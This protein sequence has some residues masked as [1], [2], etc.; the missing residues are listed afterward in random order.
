MSSNNK[1][2]KKQV[3]YTNEKYHDIDYLNTKKE[4]ARDELDCDLSTC[5]IKNV[6]EEEYYK[7]FKQYYLSGYVIVRQDWEYYSD[8]SFIITKDEAEYIKEIKAELY[9]YPL[10]DYSIGTDK[11]LIS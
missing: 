5:I 2:S 9:K 4:E 11:E 7:G 1:T 10:G 6:I 8:G 3:I